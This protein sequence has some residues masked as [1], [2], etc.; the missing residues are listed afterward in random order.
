MSIAAL[1]SLTVVF[2]AVDRRPFLFTTWFAAMFFVPVYWRSRIVTT[3]EFLEKRFNLQCRVLFLLMVVM[4]IA[5]LGLGLYLGALLLQYL[6]GWPLWQ[7]VAFIAVVTGFSVML[8]GMQ[9]VLVLDVYQAI[10]LLVTLLAVGAAAIWH[11]GGV[12]G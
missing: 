3:P 9:T 4:L 11:V 1:G 8:G 12:A 7:S 10:F 6:I 2:D 5:T